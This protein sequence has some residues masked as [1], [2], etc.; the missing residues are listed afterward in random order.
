MRTFLASEKRLSK[1]DG[2]QLAPL[3]TLLPSSLSTL[4]VLEGHE[5][6]KGYDAE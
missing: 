5:I 3:E 2:V 1:T 6:G 4:L